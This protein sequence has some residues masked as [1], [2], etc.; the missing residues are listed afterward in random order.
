MQTQNSLI[1]LAALC[2]AASVWLTTNSQAQVTVLTG[3][4]GGSPF[5]N[6]PASPPFPA[7]TLA[8][9]GDTGSGTSAFGVN[10]TEGSQYAVLTTFSNGGGTYPANAPLFGNP[11]SV[12]GANTMWNFAFS[13][14]TT[15]QLSNLGLVSGSVFTMTL[16][17]GIGD[18][19]SFDWRFLTSEPPT[20]GN[21][22]AAWVGV[23]AGATGDPQVFQTL[24]T[25]LSALVPSPTANFDSQSAVWGTFAFTATTAG[26]Y[27]I[28]VGVGDA[29]SEG[30]QSGLL[31]DNVRYALVPEPTTLTLL[32]MGAL[33]GGLL[34]RRRKA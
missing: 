20:G 14:S 16:N 24:A 25:P 8:R 6:V 10:P 9:I 28:A 17:M 13:G 4:E 19:I 22:D 12:S 11:G 33:V 3:F 23:R 26:S 5:A 18:T 2:V 29:G 15:N 21:A 1:K 27:T 31:L 30:V 32:S 34:L 7:A